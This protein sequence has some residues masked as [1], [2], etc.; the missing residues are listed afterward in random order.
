MWCWGFQP[1]LQLA[2]LHENYMF[3]LLYYLHEPLTSVFI[4]HTS[5]SQTAKV[6]LVAW[7]ILESQC[8]GVLYL[9][10]LALNRQLS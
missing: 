3:Y 4:P 7:R 8:S 1:V 6:A 9:Q 2:Q 5:P 10:V